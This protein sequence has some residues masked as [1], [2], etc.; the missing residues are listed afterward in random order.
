MCVDPFGKDPLYMLM[1]GSVTVGGVIGRVMAYQHL[2]I[3]ITN[4]FSGISPILVTAIAA[5]FLNERISYLVTA[6]YIPA[7]AGLL[8]VLQPWNNWGGLDPIGVVVCI[9]WQFASAVATFLI[10]WKQLQGG[11]EK[12]EHPFVY[13]AYSFGLTTATMLAYSAIW[14]DWDWVVHSD[15]EVLTPYLLWIGVTGLL[16]QLAVVQG[17]TMSTVGRATA[18]RYLSVPLGVLADYVFFGRVITVLQ[19][20]GSALVLLSS[21][22]VVFVKDV[23]KRTESDVTPADPEAAG[24]GSVST[25]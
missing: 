1:Q 16:T 17:L 9:I 11:G 4:L 24:Y 23:E 20:I 19:A 10:R 21:M 8:L 2:P 3:G 6:C 5:A 14:Q 15:W 12:Q 13:T 18:M 25:K 7:V 22:S